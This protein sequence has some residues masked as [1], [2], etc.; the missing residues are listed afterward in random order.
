MSK[1]TTFKLSE[2]VLTDFS[3]VA[4]DI[5]KFLLTSDQIRA[6]PPT[7]WDVIASADPS[8][9]RQNDLI[10]FETIRAQSG[11][12]IAN[13]SSGQER[14]GIQEFRVVGKRVSFMFRS[15]K[16]TDARR[17]ET[18][19]DNPDVRLVVRAVARLKTACRTTLLSSVFLS[20]LACPA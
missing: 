12:R 14:C 16:C 3:I 1:P 15:E 18:C 5:M 20:L 10:Q 17:H 8:L 6:P 19:A 7:G 13:G 9:P 11:T 2:L 4:V